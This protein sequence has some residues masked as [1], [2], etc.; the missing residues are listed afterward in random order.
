MSAGDFI[1]KF[2]G[3]ADAPAFFSAAAVPMTFQVGVHVH[4]YLPSYLVVVLGAVVSLRTGTMRYGVTVGD[5]DHYY[6]AVV[7][8]AAACA[9]Y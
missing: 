1:G 7:A 2:G 9:A 5:C 6:A 4:S 8:G 3:N